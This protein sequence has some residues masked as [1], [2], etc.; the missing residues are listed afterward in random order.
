MLEQR[1][2]IAGS[3]L[4]RAAGVAQILAMQSFSADHM[5]GGSLQSFAIVVHTLVIYFSVMIEC[6][7]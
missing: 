4:P 5:S 3:M 2:D 6:I 7:G 1:S